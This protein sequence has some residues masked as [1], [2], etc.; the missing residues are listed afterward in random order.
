MNETAAARP[1]RPMRFFLVAGEHSGDAL[2]AKLMAAL[3]VSLAERG[4]ASPVFAG[5][6]GDGMEHEGLR[7]LFPLFDVAVMGPAAILRQLPRLLRR[8]YQ[9]VDAGIAP[10]PC[11]PCTMIFQ[12]SALACTGPAR[13]VIAP[14]LP[15]KTCKPNTASTPS[16]TPAAIIGPAPPRGGTSSAG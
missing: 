13:Y 8:V 5:V 14:S 16:M 3:K 4:L 11:R 6:G 15:G 1:T 9:T 2:G 10:C 12:L 7:S